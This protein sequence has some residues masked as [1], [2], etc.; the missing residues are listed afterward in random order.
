MNDKRRKENFTIAIIKEKGWKRRLI[1]KKE[2]IN[3]REG[4]L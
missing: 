2:E 1:I 3:D 4:L